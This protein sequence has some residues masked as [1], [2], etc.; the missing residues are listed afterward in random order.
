MA[1]GICWSRYRHRLSRFLTPLPN[2]TPEDAAVAIQ[3]ARAHEIEIDKREPRTPG[4]PPAWP[5]WQGTDDRP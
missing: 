2:A 4:T 1:Q 3:A 5:R